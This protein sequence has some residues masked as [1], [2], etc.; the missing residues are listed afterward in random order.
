VAASQISPRKEGGEEQNS[1]SVLQISL[2][3]CSGGNSKVSTRPRIFIFCVLSEVC[4]TFRKA[5]PHIHPNF[6]DR[7]VGPI[8]NIPEKLKPCVKEMS[9]R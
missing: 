5:A 1:Y 8:A 3:I 4:G 6:N 2:N 7:E 9:I